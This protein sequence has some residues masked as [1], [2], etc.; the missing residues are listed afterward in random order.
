MSYKINLSCYNTSDQD[1]EL[2]FPHLLI[3]FIT[4]YTVTYV[5]NV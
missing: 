4:T 3:V 2:N 5:L 1:L